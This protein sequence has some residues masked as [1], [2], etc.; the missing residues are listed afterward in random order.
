MN[1]VIDRKHILGCLIGFSLGILLTLV[2]VNSNARYIEF[3]SQ[4]N[5]MLDSANGNLYVKTPAG[6]WLLTHKVE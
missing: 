4:G 6:A 2:F 1:F 5:E 3:G